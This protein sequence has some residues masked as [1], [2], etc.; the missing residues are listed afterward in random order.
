MHNDIHR[1]IVRRSK[2]FLFSITVFFALS[3]IF[4]FV[5]AEQAT[6]VLSDNRVIRTVGLLLVVFG[7]WGMYCSH[8]LCRMVGF[9]FMFSGIGRL[10]F[11]F[12]FIQINTWTD[13]Q[14]HGYLLALGACMS[15]C[16]FLWVA[17]TNQKRLSVS[18]SSEIN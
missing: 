12:E 9:L 13:K 6:Q 4:H 16:T 17:Y 3:S 8:R 11:P 14:T 15:L 7:G 1:T 5:W 2:Y 18:A 10:F